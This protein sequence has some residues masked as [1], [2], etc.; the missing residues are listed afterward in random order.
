MTGKFLQVQVIYKG[1]TD[2]YLS[3]FDFPW[4]FNVIYSAN[5]WLNTTKSIEFFEQII[6]LYLNNFKKI[7][8]Y[9]KEQTSLIIMDTLKGQENKVIMGLCNE[10]FCNVAMIPHNLTNNFQPLDITA[11]NLS[12]SFIANKYNACF[13]E[14]FAKQLVNCKKPA[15]VKVSFSLSLSLMDCGC[16]QISL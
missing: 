2:K 13:A 12:K 11:I 8:S 5:D 9:P 10:I 6:L 14:E 15:D 1:K 16:I 7:L 3:S 4:C